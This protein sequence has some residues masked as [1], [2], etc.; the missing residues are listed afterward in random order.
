M[1]VPYYSKIAYPW[2]NAVTGPFL[3]RMK[4]EELKRYTFSSLEELKLACFKYIEGFYNSRIPH[5]AIDMLS[6]NLKEEIYW[7]SH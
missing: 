4:R 5:S 2:H 7:Q 3:N 1:I 6:P